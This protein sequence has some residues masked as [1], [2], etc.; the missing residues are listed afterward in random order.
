MVVDEVSSWG[1]EMK[2]M[3]EHTAELD[4]GWSFACQSAE[5]IRTRDW[6]TSVVGH[7]AILVDKYTGLLLLTGS[8]HPSEWW[9]ANYQATGDPSTEP[10]SR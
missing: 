9:I 2:V 7:G 3:D 10:A 4:F 6:R 8:A 1:H 5:F